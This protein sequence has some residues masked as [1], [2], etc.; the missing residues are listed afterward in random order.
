MLQRAANSNVVEKREM[1]HIFA[2]ANPSRMWADRNTEFGSHKE[3]C[4]NLVYPANAAGID[5]ANTDGVGLKKLL[6]DDA[7][8]YMLTGGNSNWRNCSCNRGMSKNIIRA[9]G[10]FNPE[11]VKC[12]QESHCSDRIAYIPD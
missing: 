9:G 11:R 3:N 5:L 6:E 1:L 12:R 8:L 7:I 4:Q 10:F 2:Q